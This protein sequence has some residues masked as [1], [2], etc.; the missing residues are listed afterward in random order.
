M[1]TLQRTIGR[2]LDQ[3]QPRLWRITFH[4]PATVNVWLWQDEDGLTAIDAAQPWNAAAINE[5]VSRIGQPLKRI[6]ITHAHPDHAGAAAKLQRE[7]GADVFVH[8]SEVPY[9]IGGGCMADVPGYWLCRSLLRTGNF[10]RILN[11][12]AVERVE[13]IKHGDTI[14]SLKVFHTPGHTPGSISL[15][16][17]DQGL[18]F[19]GDNISNS[20]KV[21]RLNF[22]HFTLDSPQLRRSLMLFKELP[23]RLI[24]PGHGPEYFS[25]TAMQD[26]YKLMR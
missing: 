18:L 20:F 4:L 10:L 26:V 8:E 9:M 14:G 24:L 6:I 13:A 1:P 7:T 21:L 16:H 12:P 5:A 23:V 22:S 15:W 25:Y 3:V 11:P 19:C 17:E 2:V